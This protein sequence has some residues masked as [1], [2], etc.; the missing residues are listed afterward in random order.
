[1]IHSLA[2]PRLCVSNL[3]SLFKKIVRLLINIDSIKIC[4]FQSYLNNE[5]IRI[6]GKQSGRQIE[7]GEKEEDEKERMKAKC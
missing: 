4:T 1:M 3:K 6:K 2:K 7:K 5:C